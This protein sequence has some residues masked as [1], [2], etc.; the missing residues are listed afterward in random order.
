MVSLRLAKISIDVLC[1]KSHDCVPYNSNIKVL[2]DFDIVK[3][4]KG[5]D[6]NHNYTTKG[7]FRERRCSTS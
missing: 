5:H 3:D 7:S 6:D 1:R 4:L 2:S